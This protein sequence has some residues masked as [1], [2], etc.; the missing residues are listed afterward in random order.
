MD[1]VCDDA[2][3]SIGRY[4][5]DTISSHTDNLMGKGIIPRQHDESRGTRTDKFAYLMEIPAC[6]LDSDDIGTCSYDS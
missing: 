4:R 1:I 2:G 6:F 3:D 5:D